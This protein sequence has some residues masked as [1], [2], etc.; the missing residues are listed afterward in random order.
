MPKSSNNRK[1]KHK[2]NT[3]NLIKQPKPW[4]A[5]KNKFIQMNDPMPESM[6]KEDRLT[7]IRTI[8][9]NAKKE[10]DKEYPTIRRWF[11]Q[12]DAT[13]ILSFCAYYFVSHPEGIDPEVSGEGSHF[14]PYYLEILQAF[15]LFQERNFSPRPLLYDAEKLRDEIKH[16]GHLMSMRTLD[17]PQ[18]VS[19]EKEL[20]TFHLRTKM[21]ANTTAVRN[22]AYSHQMENVTKSLSFLI[23][24]EFEMI[25]GVKSSDFIKILFHLTEERNK[26]LNIH[27]SKVL[28]FLRKKT[29]RQVINAYNQAFPE[30]EKMEDGQNDKIWEGVGKNIDSLKSFLICHSDLKLQ[31]IYSFTIKDALE[32]GSKPIDSEKLKSLFYK[33]I[34]KFGDLKD[35][36]PEHIIL[37][38]PVNQ[39]PF[40]QIDEDTLFSA[41][42]CVIPHIALDILENLVWE[43]EKLREKYSLVKSQ[44]LEDEI[45]RIFKKGFPSAKIFK[46][47]RWINPQKPNVVYENDLTVLIDSFAIIVEA[48]SGSVSDPAKR[49]A[50]DRLFE[51]LRDLIEAPSEQ[52]LRFVDYL[53]VNKRQHTFTTKNGI[54]NNID[55]TGINYYIPLGVTFSHLG[56]IGSNLKKLIAAGVVKKSIEQLV[57]SI[58]FTDVESIFEILSLESEKI[59]YLSRRREIEAHLVY[60]GDELD[61]LAFYLDQ[62]FN[63]GETEYSRDIAFNLIPKSKELDPYLIGKQQGKN[64]K[65]PELAMTQWWRDILTTSANRKKQGWLETSFILLNSTLEDQKEFEGNIAKLIRNVKNGNAKNDHNWILFS[66]G[67]ERRYYVIAYYPYTI[68]DKALRDDVI[69]HIMEDEIAINAR[70]VAVIG[71]NLLKK[72]YPYSFFARKISTDLF[73]DLTL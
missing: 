27:R 12:Y 66:T 28:S 54:I 49:G 15:S 35:F 70:G 20:E 9:T 21:M 65:K 55:N 29:Y 34:W 59:H 7:L 42:W 1:R 63:I 26:R 30:N 39:K 36:N 25:Y 67:P 48:K 60:E 37:G 40:I 57:P 47:S 46:G 8:G 45:E 22:W 62:G 18:N 56:T 50:P 44:Y 10:F 53:K 58:S 24:N 68:S 64:V 16:I 52:A 61:L 71:D 14:F 72:H 38:N 73:D 4:V 32:L 5:V 13:Y 69:A 23:D 11:E 3:Q 17:I 33:L 31:N 6:N 43:N 2:K 51:T 41:I 19:S